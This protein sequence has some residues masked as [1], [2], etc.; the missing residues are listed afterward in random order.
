MPV[1]TQATVVELAASERLFA[2]GEL[3]DAMYVIVRGEVDVISEDG[4]RLAIL[5]APEVVGEMAALDWEPRSA[6]VWA[7]RPTR[8]LRVERNDLMDLL[9]D[10]GSLV[11]ALIRVL[12]ARL[13]AG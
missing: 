9:A 11:S 13:R 8:L 12:T 1:A 10:H 3:G 4:E 2:A 7:R 5:A 6:A